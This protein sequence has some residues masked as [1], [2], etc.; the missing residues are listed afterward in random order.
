[1]GNALERGPLWL[2]KRSNEKGMLLK[3]DII[4]IMIHEKRRIVI[5]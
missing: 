1:V 4:P 3:L 2:E 5:T